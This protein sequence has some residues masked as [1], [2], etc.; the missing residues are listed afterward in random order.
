MTDTIFA[1][2]TIFA[3][4]TPAGRSGVAVFRLSGPRSAEMLE[5]LT[6]KVLP[7][8]RVVATRRLYANGL[9]LDDALVS[10]FAAPRSFTGEEVVGRRSSL[11]W[12][13]R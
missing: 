13:R 8:P 7:V 2:D 5:S 1:P 9:P 4:A 11:R 6:N 10:Y 3:L 12:A